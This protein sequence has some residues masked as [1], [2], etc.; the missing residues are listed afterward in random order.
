VP[1]NT[2]D[3]TNFS[4]ILSVLQVNSGSVTRK[5]E[6][7]LFDISFLQFLIVSQPTDAM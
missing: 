2:L 7:G 3:V 1:A 5:I 4:I 6:D